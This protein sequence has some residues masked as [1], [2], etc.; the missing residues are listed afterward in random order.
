MGLRSGKVVWAWPK[1][2]RVQRSGSSAVM[3]PV[4]RGGHEGSLG[5]PS[6]GPLPAPAS[7]GDFAPVSC[8][9]GGK[10][11]GGGNC[12]WVAVLGKIL[13]SSNSPQKDLVLF[14]LCVRCDAGGTV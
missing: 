1:S 8:N 3:G 9:W 13:S 14:G 2:L 6:C 10:G 4:D 11:R 12:G 5:T 7:H